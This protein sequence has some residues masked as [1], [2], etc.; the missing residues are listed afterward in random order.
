MCGIIGFSRN[1]RTSIP[2][3]RLFMVE[4]LR[5][6]EHRGRHA[7]GAGWAEDTDPRNLWYSKAEGPASKTAS[8]LDMPKRGMTVAV[9]H[10]RH[11]THGSPRFEHNN[12]P[13]VCEGIVAV[14]NGVLDNHRELLRMVNV[15]NPGMVDSFAIPALLANAAALDAEHP[16]DVL[17]LV[18]GHAAIAWLDSTDTNQLHLARLATRP[19]AIGW[20]KRGDL[21]FAST[22]QVL[23]ALGRAADVRIT[24]IEEMGE[25]EYLRIEDGQIVEFRPIKI[26]RPSFARPEDLPRSTQPQIPGIDTDWWDAFDRTVERDPDYP[27]GIDWSQPMVH[28][29]GWA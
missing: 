27:D 5:A 23:L 26:T 8:T 4:A 21:V 6:I 9:G 7:T 12:H 14:H 3:G 22:P 19:L 15:D 20:T 16:A 1:R 10:T 2:N 24:G 25:G 17:A 29:R 28:R 18:E 11:A 13:V